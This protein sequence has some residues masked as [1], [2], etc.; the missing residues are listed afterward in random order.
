MERLKQSLEMLDE[1]IFSLE[2]KIGITAGSQR[3]ITK[4]QNEILKQSRLRETEVLATAQKIAMR[5][6]HT[7]AHVE[8]ILRD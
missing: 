3:E 6:D 1:A 2:D 7:I 5:L 8:R 4:K